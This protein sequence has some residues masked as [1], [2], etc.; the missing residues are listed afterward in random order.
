[1]PV[2][3]VPVPWIG[4]THCRE[5]RF[6][7]ADFVERVGEADRQVERVAVFDAREPV[8]GIA[9]EERTCPVLKILCGHVAQ[10]IRFLKGEAAL[11]GTQ[12]R[13]PRQAGEA[14]K[15]EK[16]PAQGPTRSMNRPI[17]WVWRSLDLCSLH[18]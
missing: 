4:L 10:G 12:R 13:G 14:A 2:G 9:G 15:K 16:R 18:P 17:L 7:V 11:L 6:P 8:C 5:I 3:K 1:M